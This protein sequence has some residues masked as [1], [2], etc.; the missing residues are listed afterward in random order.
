[1]SDAFGPLEE[2]FFAAG[3]AY[4]EQREDGSSDQDAY[5][6]DQRHPGRLTMLRARLGSALTAAGRRVVL[7]VRILELGVA[8]ALSTRVER[9]L[10]AAPF[11]VA[12]GTR[13]PRYIPRLAR[14]ALLVRGSL[15]VLA[16]TAA[17]FPAAA[18]LAA[19]GAI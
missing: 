16:F 11:W 14:S 9:A 4:E 8:V 5:A 2:A 7:Q 15:L 10:L 1:M 17:T 6:E 12:V 19:T 3:H 13:V 18:V